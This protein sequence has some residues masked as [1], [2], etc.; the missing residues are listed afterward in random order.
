[1]NRKTI[2]VLL[3]FLITNKH[4]LCAQYD[5]L[6]FNLNEVSIIATKI[7]KPVAQTP[8]SITVLTTEEIERLPYLTLGKLL[9]E[10]AGIYLVG[11]GQAPGSN[12]SIFMRGANSNQTAIF[13]DGVRIQDVSTVNGVVDL[14]ELPLSD[15]ERVEILRGA[16]GTLYGSPAAGG[17]IRITTKGKSN[18]AGFHGNTIARGGLFKEGGRDAGTALNIGYTTTSGWY[19]QSGLDLFRSVGF[20]ATIDTGYR[21]PGLKPDADNWTKL[22]GALKAGYSSEK[23]NFQ[24]GYRKLDSKTD[25]DQ[26]AF[27]DDDNYVLD[28]TRDLAFMQLDKKFSPS[29]SMNFNGNW[30]ATNRS[31]VN[32]SSYV[33]STGISDRTYVT[34]DYTGQQIMAEINAVYS[35]ENFKMTL[36]AS[37]LQEAMTQESYVYSA[38]YDPFIYESNT[39]LDTIDPRA[40]TL[41]ANIH[42][43]FNG[44]LISPTLKKLNLLAGARII[45]HSIVGAN[46]TFELSPSYELNEN[47]FLYLSYSTGFTNPS[48]Y[49]LY[50]PEVYIPYDGQP[51]SG[52]SRGNSALKPERSRSFE[53]GIKDYTSSGFE[54]TI[55]IFRSVTDNLI[56]YVYLWDA[57]IPVDQ[58]AT[59]FNR[60]DY[61]GDR[62]MNIGKI[63]SQ[64]AEFTL[65]RKL[66]DE[67]TL[68]VTASLVDGYLEYEPISPDSSLQVQVF[69][70]GSFLQENERYQGLVR[71][72]STFLTRLNYAFP[73]GIT[74]GIQYSYVGRRGDVYYNSSLGP[75]GG[76]SSKSVGAYSLIDIDTHWSI[77]QR[78]TAS[79]Q[80]ENILNTEYQEILGFRTRGRGVQIRLAYSF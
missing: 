5:T 33:P 19:F 64:G 56:D 63:F 45:H 2:F 18:E 24:I 16:E 44:K 51:S 49:Q 23:T 62:Y 31:S 27:Q 72:P 39:N 58:L 65:K 40:T 71:R 26:A 55:S 17:V 12:Q 43:D 11:A 42:G 77:N 7:E 3:S 34:E 15:I 60:D 69:A 4:Q 22:S 41:S 1:M 21:L 37:G 73:K 48:L 54:W 14:S 66:T 28:F 38:L 78:L 79:M 6:K 59:D 47:T 75:Y 46:N 76:L 57:T 35:G 74:L 36:G 20:N 32:D 9:D 13:L 8:R 25:I 29:F 10:Q 52:L 30:T 68:S 53:V 61:R 67:L 50:A 70:T 80:L